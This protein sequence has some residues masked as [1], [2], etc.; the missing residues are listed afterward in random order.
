MSRPHLEAD[1]NAFSDGLPAFLMS[2]GTSE[3][4]CTDG[5][6]ILPHRIAQDPSAT[7]QK[8]PPALILINASISGRGNHLHISS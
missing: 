7:Y 3:I 5:T 6:E 2:G 1:E 8:S 4:G